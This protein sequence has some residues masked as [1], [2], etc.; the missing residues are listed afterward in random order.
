MELNLTIGIATYNRQE[1]AVKLVHE[2]YQLAS[3]FGHAFEVILVNDGGARDILTSLPDA[4]NGKML[5]TLIDLP[6]NKGVYGA[7]LAAM[8]AARGKWYLHCDDDDSINMLTLKSILSRLSYGMIPCPGMSDEDSKGLVINAIQFNCSK[9]LYGPNQ[10]VKLLD[11][12]TRGRQKLS[13]VEMSLNGLLFKMTD[14]VKQRI[15]EFLD[16][17]ITLNIPRKL[18]SDDVIIPGYILRD[19][20]DEEIY[21]TRDVNLFMMDYYTKD[22]HIALAKDVIKKNPENIQQYARKLKIN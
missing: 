13:Q 19:L 2:I 5:L 14:Q 9:I 6:E 1:K 15:S 16:E 12:C 22:E 4:F 17:Y 7:K 11:R 18:W 21:V 20:P 3:T 8:N 10:P